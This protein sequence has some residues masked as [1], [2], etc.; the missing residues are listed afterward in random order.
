MEP[1]ETLSNEH[2]L[3]RQFLSNLA[4]AAEKLEEDQRP[5]REFFEKAVQF[6]R[7]FADTF[8]HIK[9][10]HVLFVRLA[11]KK[12]GELDGQID[13]L[14]HQHERARNYIATIVDNLD[15]YAEGQSIQVG[16]VL[17]STS[18]YVSLIRN[19]IHREDHVFFPMAE[20]E[21]TAEEEAQLQVEFDR[22]RAK[23]GEDAFEAGHKL[24][25]DMGSM[26]V[27]M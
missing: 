4:L 3:I 22:A 26:L 14:R 13:A 12:N 17:E 10:E 11:Q 18:A 21:L 1:L 5:P 24:I 9:E 27:H 7:T 20:K 23:C 25:V 16:R 8:H 19:H 2:G 15:G 6:A